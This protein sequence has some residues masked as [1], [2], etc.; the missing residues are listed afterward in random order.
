MV[1]ITYLQF[2]IPIFIQNVTKFGETETKL[3]VAFTSIWKT[4]SSIDQH[5]VILSWHSKV[6]DILRPLRTSDF[7]SKSFPKK[8]IN[9]RY[10][11]LL[12]VRWFTVDTKIRFRLEHNQTIASLLED[13]NLIYILDNYEVELTK[14]KIKYTETVIAVW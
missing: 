3:L 1:F 13:P 12:Q 2:S 11:E 5:T 4:L 6:E 7:V 9:D 8:T 14:V 10:I